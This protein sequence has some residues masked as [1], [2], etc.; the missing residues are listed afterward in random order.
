MLE[1][2]DRS[3]GMAFKDYISTEMCDD[4]GENMLVIEMDGVKLWIKEQGELFA[5][6]RVRPARFKVDIDVP[7]TGAAASGTTVASSI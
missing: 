3:L 7:A 5:V 1:N 2:L 6:S 4:Y